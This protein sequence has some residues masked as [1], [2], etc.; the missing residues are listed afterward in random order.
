MNYLFIDP[1]LTHFG[2]VYAVTKRAQQLTIKSAICLKTQ[3]EAKIRHIYQADDEWRRLSELYRQI[4]KFIAAN[5]SEIDLIIIE[6]PHGGAKSAKA[7]RA[8][9]LIK[10][11][12][13][14]LF[15]QYVANIKIVLPHDIKKA[16]TGNRNANKDEIQTKIDEDKRIIWE[17]EKPKYKSDAEHI[18]DAIGC[19]FLT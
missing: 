10:G 7:M 18:Y 15:A 6:L 5:V 14:A 13:N 12:C 17:C 19:W 8:M 1:S 11:F 3:P 4:K 9:G 16:V 2:I